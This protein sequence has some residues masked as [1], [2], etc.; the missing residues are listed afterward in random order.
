MAKEFQT[1]RFEHINAEKVQITNHLAS[2]YQRGE[3]DVWVETKGNSKRFMW[4]MTS[5]AEK[6]A[7]FTG[8]YTKKCYILREKTSGNY[9]F[10]D[11]NDN[12][13]WLYNQSFFGSENYSLDDSIRIDK[14]LA[15]PA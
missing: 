6:C 11:M 4:Q 5:Q 7:I 14:W 2:N 10:L 12:G 15:E 1:E 8:V 3:L 13:I 9:F